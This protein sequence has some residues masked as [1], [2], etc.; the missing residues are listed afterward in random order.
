ML[1]NYNYIISYVK[2][3]FDLAF[4]IYFLIEGVVF[5]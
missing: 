2:L 4:D 5:C 1:K 3:K